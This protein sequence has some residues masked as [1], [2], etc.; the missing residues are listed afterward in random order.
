MGV[1][2]MET[3]KHFIQAENRR[4]WQANIIIQNDGYSRIVDLM[5]YDGNVQVGISWIMIIL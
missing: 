3:Q 2:D 5:A 1:K 4:Q